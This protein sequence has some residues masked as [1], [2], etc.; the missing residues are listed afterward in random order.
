LIAK[1]RYSRLLLPRD[2]A[3][4]EPKGLVESRFAAA[5]APKSRIGIFIHNQVRR[6]M[7]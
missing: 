7:A 4:T 2:L 1:W 5:F 3:R 6:L